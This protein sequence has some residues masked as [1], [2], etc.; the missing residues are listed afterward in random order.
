MRVDLC[1]L[2]ISRI[3]GLTTPERMVL[4]ETFV[5]PDEMSGLRSHDFE[6]LLRRNP[7][8]LSFNYVSVMKEVEVIL[9]DLEESGIDLV[10]YSDSCYPEILREIF[11]PP[12]L[13]YKRGD[14][15]EESVPAVAVVGTRKATVS[16]M[17]AAYN[18]G[19][20]ISAFKTYLV[21]G[22]AAGIDGAVHRGSAE[23]SGLM[24]AVLGNGIDYIYPYEHRSLGR[25]I[26]DLGGIILSE[27]PPGTPPH[28]FNFPARNRII[29]GL[30]RAVLVVEAPAKSGAL[31]TADFA[32]EQG[33]EVFVHRS[34]L[35]SDK[36][37]GCRN[38]VLDGAVV[39]DSAEEFLNYREAV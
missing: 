4:A 2:F 5:S 16:G 25:R 14:V 34:S 28:R 33:R 6:H 18:I 38:L 3:S 9:S 29:S 15:L 21:S 24:I 1:R 36:G 8:S 10:F 31:I 20:E 17:D 7:G 27:Y 19:F 37:E 13:L 32:L 23:G 12:Y 39:V 35:D 30:S 22:L 11:D 26:L